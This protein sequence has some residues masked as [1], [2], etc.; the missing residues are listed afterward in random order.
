MLIVNRYENKQ[1]KLHFPQEGKKVVFFQNTNSIIYNIKK[2][3]MLSCE[4]KK[5]K[6]GQKRA[7]KGTT[8]KKQEIISSTTETMS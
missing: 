1:T 7:K 6:K 4:V 5:G 3:V 8:K 2:R